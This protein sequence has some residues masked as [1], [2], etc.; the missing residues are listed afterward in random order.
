MRSWT[1]IRRPRALEAAA[2]FVR[3]AADPARR[4]ARHH[5]HGEPELRLRIEVRRGRER[6][7]TH[8]GHV[9]F[10]GK[11]QKDPR[12]AGERSCQRERI[13]RNLEPAL[14]EA[15]LPASADGIG[16]TRPAGVTIASASGASTRAPGRTTQRR[17]TPRPTSRAPGATIDSTSST[18]EPTLT[19][20][21]TLT[22]L[23]E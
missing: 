16:T 2:G 20:T 3:Q 5:P 6:I 15:H 12:P 21:P 19:P 9:L 11:R 4:R 7:A 1:R 8:V 14:E 10:L 17:I 22:P 18:S 23:V 13:G